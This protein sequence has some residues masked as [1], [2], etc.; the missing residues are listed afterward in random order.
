M[1]A[2]NGLAQY[3]IKSEVELDNL[4]TSYLDKLPKGQDPQKARKFFQAVRD[5]L[6]GRPIGEA[7]PEALRTSQAVAD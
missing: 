3:G 6:L 2:R 1:A 4:L 5:D 7:A